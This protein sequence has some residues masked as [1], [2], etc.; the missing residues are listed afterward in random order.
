MNAYR[1]ILTHFSTR[2]G[3]GVPS[4][5]GVEPIDQVILAFDFMRVKFNE[6]WMLPTL[7]EVIQHVFEKEKEVHKVA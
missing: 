3:G 2:V 4:L 5:G 7:N 6:L 1:T